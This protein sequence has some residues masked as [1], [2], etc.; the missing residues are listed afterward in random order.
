MMSLSALDLR[1]NLGDRPLITTCRTHLQTRLGIVEIDSK[2][3]GHWWRFGC[4]AGLYSSL[5]AIIEYPFAH[6][7]TTIPIQACYM[8]QPR[9]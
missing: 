7:A 8:S 5:L 1:L 6:D 2:H 9:S 3:E 4:L